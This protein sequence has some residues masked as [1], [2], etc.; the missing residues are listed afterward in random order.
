MAH[1]NRRE[2]AVELGD[3]LDLPVVM[4][5]E[6]DR[7][8]TGRRAL[9]AYDPAASH[10]L[11]VQDDAIPCRDLVA[12]CELIA[13]AAGARP[14]SLY[15]GK[16]R[17]HQS[18]ITPA[19]RRA[20]KRGIRF[21]AFDGPWWG[22]AIIVP[23]ADIP[24]LVEWCDANPQVANYDRRIAKFY[25]ARGVKCWYTVPSLVDHR[26]VA[27]NPS[28]IPGRTGN[29][30]AHYFLGREESPLAIDWSADSVYGLAD[31]VV[32]NADRRATLAA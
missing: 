5:R 9:L 10:H 18:T 23:T 20:K 27:E 24:E 14:V 16:V 25:R 3:E 26:S 11:V 6:N 2:W 32:A 22:V 31:H 8:E 13:A 19:V 29:R 4:D 17:P 7:W 28:L 21:L 12:G 30:R 1:P 15:T